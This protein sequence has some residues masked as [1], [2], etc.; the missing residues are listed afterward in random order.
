MVC[1]SFGISIILYRNL[2]KIIA[3]ISVIAFAS[4]G[5]G[6]LTTFIHPASTPTFEP[7][8][9]MS[10]LPSPTE[11]ATPQPTFTFTETFTPYPTET[12]L[13]TFTSSP[14]DTPVP[15]WS[16]RGPGELVVPILLY[17]H[18]GTSP[19]N[20]PYYTSPN[21]FEQQMYLL[22]EWGYQTISVEL[23]TQ[24]ITKGAAL[25]PRPII[26][27]FDDGSETVLTTALPI[28]Q[29]YN[30]TG[31]AYIVYNYIGITN[32]MDT[33]QIRKL[34]ANG[35]EIGSH[36]LSHVSLTERTDRQKDEIVDSRRKLQSKLGVPILTFAYPFGAYNEDSVHYAHFA[37]YI[38]AMGLGDS[39][40][41]GP[42]NLFYL[43]RQEIDNS[44]NIQ[45]FAASLPWRG[46]MDNL[47]IVTVIP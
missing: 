3:A 43:Y 26:L 13:P 2:Y 28:M 44:N 1:A 19:S 46:D 10:P 45:S 17:H 16:F 35:W 20:S 7:T 14:T 9:T 42:K 47:P 12:P 8:W 31:T 30:F 25:P 33:D 36:S 34:Y 21:D 4:I 40:I 41:Q 29:K 5:C 37:G 23:L 22:H 38:A 27:T 15:Q 11:P 32:Y 18:I 24:A 6:A 39:T